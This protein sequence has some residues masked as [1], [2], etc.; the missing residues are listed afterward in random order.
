MICIAKDEENISCNIEY[1]GINIENEKSLH[2]SIKKYYSKPGDRLEVKLEGY[3]ID[4]VR[5][6]LLI[7]IQTKNFSAMKNKLKTLLQNHKVQLV[8]PIAKEK[9]ICTLEN[10]NHTII[11]NRKSPKKGCLEDLFSELIRIPGLIN[12]V[13][14]SFVVLITK[15]QEIRCKDGKGSWRRKGVS[16]VDK[17]LLEVS[18]IIHLTCK[19]D[20]LRFIPD[21]LPEA[22]TNKNLAKALSINT[23]KATKITYCLKKMGII[24]EVGKAKRELLYKVIEN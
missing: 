16:L 19:E 4:I 17:H 13:N 5:D 21:T 3:V 6:D 7:E 9:Y 14:F 10:D 1:K 8:Y 20:F 15:E 2:S 22:F 12:H 11:S 18:E 24:E 23:A